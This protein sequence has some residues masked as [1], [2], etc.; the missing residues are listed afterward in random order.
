MEV[1]ELED[2]QFN[3]HM[4]R[5]HEI[6]TGHALDAVLV[7]TDGEL[8]HQVNKCCGESIPTA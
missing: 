7:S 5:G 3:R 1:I 6:R 4:R 2:S 8:W